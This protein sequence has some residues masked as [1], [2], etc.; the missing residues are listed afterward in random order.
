MPEGL[1][2]IGEGAFTACPALKQTAV[3]QSVTTIS[4]HAFGYD[5]K[6][7]DYALEDDFSM[8]VYSGSAGE[9]YAKSNKISYTTID[10]SIKQYAFIIVAAAVLLAAVIFALVL[11]KK[12]RKRASAE[13]RKADKKEQ[14]RIEEK[15][16]EKILEEDGSNEE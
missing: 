10:K 5:I 3:P 15:S 16:Y 9:K 11:M 13:V 8:S 7:D 2:T 12:G 14:E 6:D 1:K 4:G